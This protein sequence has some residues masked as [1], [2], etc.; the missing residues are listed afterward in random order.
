MNKKDCFLQI[1]SNPP[2]L[3]SSKE[4]YQLDHTNRGKSKLIAQLSQTEQRKLTVDN[5]HLSVGMK[6]TSEN[7]FPVLQPYN[8]DCNFEMCAYTNLKQSNGKDTA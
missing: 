2:S 8:G 4:Q 6:F 7:E 5:M 3:F 1:S